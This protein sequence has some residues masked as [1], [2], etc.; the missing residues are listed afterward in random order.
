MKEDTVVTVEQG[1]QRT[2]RALRI[3][4]RIL[5]NTKELEHNRLEEGELDNVIS[6]MRH[7]NESLAEIDAVG[8]S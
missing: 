2:R 1:L 6:A 5:Y 3:A 7:I 8:R 4:W